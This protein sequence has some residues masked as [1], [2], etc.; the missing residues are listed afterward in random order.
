MNINA[1]VSISLWKKLL[2]FLN[3]NLLI[4]G[5][6][7]NDNNYPYIYIVPMQNMGLNRFEISGIYN[8]FEIYD[9]KVYKLCPNFPV[10]Y[11]TND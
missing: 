6:L 10:F 4:P 11:T 1:G 9:L 5:L 3:P 8:Q 2:S 7:L